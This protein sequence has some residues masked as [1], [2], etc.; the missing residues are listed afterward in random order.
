MGLTQIRGLL[1]TL[2][3]DFWLTWP[4][5]FG[6]CQKRTACLLLTGRTLKRLVSSLAK[7]TEDV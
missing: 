6:F 7:R 1:V 5:L 2:K 3:P 4:D